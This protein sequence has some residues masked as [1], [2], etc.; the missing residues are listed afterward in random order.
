MSRRR[1]HT[2]VSVCVLVSEFSRGI[3]ALMKFHLE[4]FNFSKIDGNMGG[5]VKGFARKWGGEGVKQNW[6]VRPEMEG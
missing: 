1:Q 5:G 6:G 3:N 4:L 2:G